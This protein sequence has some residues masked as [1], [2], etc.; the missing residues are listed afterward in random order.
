[1]LRLDNSSINSDQDSIAKLL[2]EY[3]RLREN[4]LFELDMKSKFKCESKYCI[5]VINTHSS[6][7]QTIERT[8]ANDTTNNAISNDNSN[9]FSADES[10]QEEYEDMDICEQSASNNTSD[11]S[12]SE[13]EE[14]YGLVKSRTWM[15][16]WKSFED[17]LDEIRINNYEAFLENYTNM[18]KLHIK[19]KLPL[20][21]VSYKAVFMCLEPRLLK[22]VFDLNLFVKNELEHFGCMLDRGF[23]FNSF[24]AMEF[25]RTSP[26][27]FYLI[28]SLAI[29]LYRIKCKTHYKMILVSI[30]QNL[31]IFINRQQYDEK[32]IK[33]GVKSF[34]RSV[35]LNG[36]MDQMSLKKFLSIDQR[37]T[38]QSFDDSFDEEDDTE[39]SDYSNTSDSEDDIDHNYF[40]SDQNN[41]NLNADQNTAQNQ[42]SKTLGELIGVRMEY[43]K[44]H[45]LSLKQLS[46]ITIKNSLRLYTGISVDRL[47]IL[48]DALK[49][50]VMF[51][52]EINDILKLAETRTQT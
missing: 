14:N 37:R 32:F 50:Y 1:M 48:P 16:V 6:I 3:L 25:N 5:N 18:I 49:K 22:D 33:F 51:D 38:R 10:D 31:A 29:L 4:C 21:Y 27:P 24:Q 44:I 7:K 9:W 35:I 12:S 47:Q 41:N 15:N 26:E 52:D 36:I 42:Q 2:L 11:G 13:S 43:S 28:M 20:S 17:V 45:P 8:S 30:N 19:H 23:L 34:L 40:I 46:R 39:I